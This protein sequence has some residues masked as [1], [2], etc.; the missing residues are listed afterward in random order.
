MVFPATVFQF[1]CFFTPNA[2]IFNF[3]YQ[4]L[5]FVQEAQVDRTFCIL[6]P[7]AMFDSI[8]DKGL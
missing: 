3:T 1:P 5:F 2:I 6:V 8:F 7:D 4:L